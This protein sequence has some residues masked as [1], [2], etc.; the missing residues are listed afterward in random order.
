LRLRHEL[1]PFDLAK[2]E[3]A[4]LRAIS[5]ATVERLKRDPLRLA[6]TER[7]LSQEIDEFGQSGKTK[8]VL[9][10][11]RAR[12][13]ITSDA[14]TGCLVLDCAMPKRPTKQP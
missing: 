7:D 11:T 9:T 13:A 3:F 10:L 5:R 2:Q 12:A 8:P 4:T 6:R 14:A 1:P